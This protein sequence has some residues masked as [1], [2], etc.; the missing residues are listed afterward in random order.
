[1]IVKFNKLVRDKVPDG[2]RMEGLF[3]ITEMKSGDELKEYHVAKIVEEL[4]E[5]MVARDPFELVDVL[6]AVLACAQNNHG[7]SRTGLLNMATDK[8]NKRGGF[9]DGVVLLEV[10]S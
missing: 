6:E 9:N 2:I 8:C 1:M 7:I 4:A 10:F 5:Y 3:C